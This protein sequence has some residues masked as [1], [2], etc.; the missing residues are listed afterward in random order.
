MKWR[1]RNGLRYTYPNC[2]EGSNLFM[3]YLLCIHYHLSE[4]NSVKFIL[5]N[6]A[7]INVIEIFKSK[8]EYATT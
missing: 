3:K 7:V 6:I 4:I 2:I 5:C 8:I 1:D